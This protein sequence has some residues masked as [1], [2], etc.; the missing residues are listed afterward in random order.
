MLRTPNYNSEVLDSSI[1]DLNLSINDSKIICERTNDCLTFEEAST[2]RISEIHA[3]I[4]Q[5]DI[6]ELFN[7]EDDSLLTV[8]YNSLSVVFVGD[9]KARFKQILDGN[10][11]TICCKGAISGLHIQDYEDLIVTPI[12]YSTSRKIIGGYRETITKNDSLY[13]LV[14]KV[15]LGTFIRMIP[16]EQLALNFTITGNDASIE[17]KIREVFIP[18]DTPGASSTRFMVDPSG[19]CDITV[20]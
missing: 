13:Y 10:T 11:I 18:D 5:M 17:I 2:S 4:K 19:R 6:D 8:I 20:I 15:L 1:E 14:P 9:A 16:V 3:K 7:S 12:A